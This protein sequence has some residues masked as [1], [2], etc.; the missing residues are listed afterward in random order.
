MAFWHWAWFTSTL[1][2][3]LYWL[4]WKC[5]KSTKFH[6]NQK[7]QGFLQ[8]LWHIGSLNLEKIEVMAH[9]AFTI[10]ATHQCVIPIT[11]GVMRQ[12]NVC[13]DV[14]PMNVAHLLLGKSWIIHFCAKDN[15]EENSYSFKY[16]IR[17]Q[18]CFQ[19]HQR[20]MLHII[21]QTLRTTHEPW[22]KNSKPV[23]SDKVAKRQL[24]WTRLKSQME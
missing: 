12:L 20:G 16:G 19:H 17:G 14:L 7:F 22:V 6:S 4:I 2:V 3:W 18:L 10:M 9:S 23:T 1:M 15:K 24:L 11:F 5:W 13:C 8:L 21:F